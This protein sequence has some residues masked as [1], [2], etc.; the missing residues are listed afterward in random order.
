MGNRPSGQT[1]AEGA[2][3]EL[4][5][6]GVQ[7]EGIPGDLG[8]SGR[9]GDNTDDPAAQINWAEELE[10]S[11]QTVLDA[12]TSWKF[13]KDRIVKTLSPGQT[14]AKEITRKLLKQR[15]VNQAEEIF[16][17][18]KIRDEV[19]MILDGFFEETNNEE[20][21]HNVESYLRE[22]LTRGWYVSLKDTRNKFK[23]LNPEKLKELY[24]PFK[25]RFLLLPDVPE[26][27]N[28]VYSVSAAKKN[29]SNSVWIR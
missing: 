10:V 25:K 28:I 9:I 19:L 22:Q 27:N 8:E 24:S 7:R 3:P 14:L 26:H 17:S 15:G 5:G 16:R 29:K 4:F 1:F 6:I 18:G 21:K 23:D 13:V 12:A 11:I 2:N 20:E